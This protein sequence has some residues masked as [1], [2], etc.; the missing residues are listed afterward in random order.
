MKDRVKFLICILIV[1][2]LGAAIYFYK[3]EFIKNEE[4]NIA[5]NNQ[6]IEE[7][8]EKVANEDVY[9]E[10]DLNTNNEE[11]INNTIIQNDDNQKNSSIRNDSTSDDSNIHLVKSAS[12]SGFAGSSL[13]AIKLYSDGSVYLVTYDGEGFDES[14]IGSK[15]LIATNADD[16][17]EITYDENNKD[18]SDDVGSVVVKGSN[19]NVIDN[20]YGWII[21]EK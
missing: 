5:N 16:I 18:N 14:N 1:I 2:I 12:P 10:N 11:L 15:E 21:F 4:K 17:Y 7:N 6:I 8:N 13:Q 19:L 20:G 3:L 9:E